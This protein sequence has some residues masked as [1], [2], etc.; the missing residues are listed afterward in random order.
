MVF[1]R[2]KLLIHKYCV[3]VEPSRLILNYSGPNPQVAIERYIEIMKKVFAIS[4]SEIQEKEFN[5]DKSGKDEK[6]KI[7]FEGR[8]DFDKFTY[9]WLQGDLSGT[10][11]PSKEFGKE[12][13]IRVRIRGAVRAEYPQDT[14]WQR[15]LFYELLRVFYHKVLY[16]SLWEKYMSECREG[17]QLFMNEMKAFFNLLQRGAL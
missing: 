8:K 13:T 7:A 5:W 12:G 3:E 4:D 14:I 10:I 1:A 15:S 9:L 6:F 2:T 11:S 16:V 17:I